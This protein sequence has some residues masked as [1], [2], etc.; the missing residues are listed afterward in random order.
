MRAKRSLH[1]TLGWML[2]GLVP[3]LSCCSM[4]KEK[5]VMKSASNASIRESFSSDAGRSASLQEKRLLVRADSLS[6]EYQAEIIPDG[7]FTYSPLSG[8]SG[9]ALS[10]RV[11][12]V[13]KEKSVERDSAEKRLNVRETMS[14]GYKREEAAASSSLNKQKNE[15][16]GNGGL[17]LAAVCMACLGGLVWCYSK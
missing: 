7:N 13:M 2:M 17:L 1:I 9:R 4:M 6:D 8:F 14:E 11:K 3:V 10:V 15:Q 12:G 16:A 5:N